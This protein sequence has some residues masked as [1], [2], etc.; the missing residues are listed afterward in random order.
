LTHT[1]ADRKLV[2]TDTGIEFD[3]DA[4]KAADIE[5]PARPEGGRD[6]NHKAIPEESPML[7][8]H[9]IRSL[10]KRYEGDVKAKITDQLVLVPGWWFLEVVPFSQMKHGENGAVEGVWGWV[11]LEFARR[12]DA[13][14]SLSPNLGRARGVPTLPPK[15]TVHISVKE[16]MKQEHYQPKAKW[17]GEPT[18]VE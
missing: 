6:A 13:N 18:W 16:R 9:Y 12:F 14:Y 10:D 11:C 1:L 15:A 4:I 7:P 8:V 2:L 17:D 5:L 3:M